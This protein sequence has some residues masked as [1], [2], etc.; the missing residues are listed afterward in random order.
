[1]GKHSLWSSLDNSEEH[2]SNLGPSKFSTDISAMFLE[3]GLNKVTKHA[4][5]VELEPN[6]GVLHIYGDNAD[7]EPMPKRHWNALVRIFEATPI[8]NHPR[9]ALLPDEIEI[10]L[11]EVK[12]RV[13][14]LTKHKAERATRKAQGLSKR[15]EGPRSSR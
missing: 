1:M 13:R 11:D 9:W 6:L 8:P 14:E 7:D 5:R 2:I 4:W 3:E 10:A 12:R 15:S